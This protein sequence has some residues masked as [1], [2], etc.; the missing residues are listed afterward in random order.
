MGQAGQSS[1]WPSF[2]PLVTDTKSMSLPGQE[3]AT[4]CWGWGA[5]DP[6]SAVT[7]GTLA[8]L[9]GSLIQ[10]GGGERAL[11]PGMRQ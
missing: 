4:R 8:P 9:S 5:A 7:L 11:C 2:S 10:K 6:E 1:E 3:N